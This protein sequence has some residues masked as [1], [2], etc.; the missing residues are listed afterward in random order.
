MTDWRSGGTDRLPV[1]FA[2]PPALTAWE[3]QENYKRHRFPEMLPNDLKTRT[4]CK[5]RSLSSRLKVYSRDR[6]S[7]SHG[8]IAS[9]RMQ[10][11]VGGT[12]PKTRRRRETVCRITRYLIVRLS[13][14]PVSH[15]SSWI[16]SI[17]FGHVVSYLR[18]WLKSLDARS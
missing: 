5:H 9:V 8:K 6:V 18:L 12:L 4:P 14:R 7:S 13:V 2:R 11:S 16:K 1:R 15:W 10:N 17:V 3:L